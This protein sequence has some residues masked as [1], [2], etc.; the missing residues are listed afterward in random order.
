MC[1]GLFFFFFFFFFFPSVLGLLSTVN[2]PFKP[3]SKQVPTMVT[4]LV[5]PVTTITAHRRIFGE[6]WRT[7]DVPVDG[8]F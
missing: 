6:L 3:L 1:I 8:L 2:W 4:S 7:A 5:S